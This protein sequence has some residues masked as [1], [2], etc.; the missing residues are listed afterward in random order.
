[1]EILGQDGCESGVCG[2]GCSLI[3][4]LNP[5]SFILTSVISIVTTY[6]L[7]AEQLMA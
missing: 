4:I 2:M 6:S 5:D 7:P 3:C 1:M